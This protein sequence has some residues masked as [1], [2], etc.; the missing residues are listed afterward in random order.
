MRCPFCGHDDTQ[1]KD[2]RP[3]EDNSAIRRRRYCPSC[4]A[5]FTTF[6][7]IQLRELTVIKTNGKRET[8]DR[9]KIV[10]SLQI[11]LRKRDV[12]EERVD[13]IVNSMVRQ[14]ESTGESEIPSKALG[15]MVMKT[16]ASLDK[17]AY[18][19]Y[20]SVYKDFREPGDFNEFVEKL[21]IE[22]D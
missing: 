12:E 6:E 18:V 22:A 21:R 11:A 20:A 7:R 15:E 3:T 14:L 1:V 10:R 8:F 5:R 16:L 13:R 17:V 19:R 4:G 9:D 2:S